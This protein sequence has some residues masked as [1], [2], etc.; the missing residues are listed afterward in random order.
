MGGGGIDGGLNEDRHVVTEGVSTGGIDGGIDGGDNVF[1]FTN[2]GGIDGG[3]G[4]IG[5]VVNDGGIDGAGG[6]ID[7]GVNV[8]TDGRY[9]S[10]KDAETVDNNHSGNTGGLDG[11]GTVGDAS[12]DAGSNGIDGSGGL[13]GGG[14][15]G[16]DA[17]SEAGSNGIDDGGAVG[18]M[19]HLMTASL[20]SAVWL[21]IPE[22]V[23]PVN[24]CFNKWKLVDF[25]V[26][27]SDF[28]RAF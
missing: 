1:E 5:D 2:D 19:P 9:D 18:G 27:A 21:L 10:N 12:R 20:S 3:G 15:V 16:G 14:T 6:G 28:P 26:S 11:G 24:N 25:C 17:S 4:G 22:T 7:D 23:T 8:D 13:D